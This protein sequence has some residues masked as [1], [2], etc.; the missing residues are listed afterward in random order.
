MRPMP[1]PLRLAVCIATTTTAL[2]STSSVGAQEDAAALAR[3]EL[4]G[5][6]F[7]ERNFTNPATDY[8]SSCAEC[9]ASGSDVADRGARAFADYTPTSMTA[10]K[11]TTLR[12]TPT[13]L[14]VSDSAAFG[15]DGR[16]TSLE[17][18]VLDKLVGATLGWKPSDRERALAAVHF[19][20]L[21]EG[22][23]PYAASFQT[24]YAV[25]LESLPV[26]DAVRQGAL[27]IAD[28]VRSL[29]A[30]RTAPW[31]A[32]VS[33]NRIHPKP[34]GDETP[35]HYA[36][37]IWSRLGNQEG[38][39]LVKRPMGFTQEAYRGFKTFF[40]TTPEGTEPVGNC[41]ACH[42]PPR[43]TDGRFHDSGI[44]E[45]AY[46]RVH[47]SGKA[48][49]YPKPA[50]PSATTAATPVAS[51]ASRIDLGRFNTAP[52]EA[53]SLGAFKTPTLRNLTGTDP[54]FHDGAAATLEDAV[55]AKIEVAKL[56][57]AGKLPW[58]DPEIQKI[59]LTEADVA[60]L[61]AFLR[62]LH[63]VGKAGFREYLIHLAE[64]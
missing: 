47:G 58:V 22:E 4:G 11:E 15:W 28:Y 12:N 37:G 32:F 33:M 40:R 45:L 51:D 6:L 59:Q 42:V 24:A 19:T 27:A 31:D 3:I 48:A 25:D 23:P 53:G 52:E 29:H 10:T 38:R 14:G 2:L 16:Y 36:F 50:A 57:Q 62:Q 34:V 41:V 49:T 60:P 35:E 8:G 18:L 46:D 30:S 20:L 55:R 21:H 54:Y 13:L 56:A 7:Q 44:S 9:H 63:D 5:R 39:L 61:V 17:D 1:K 43:F 64:D 26:E